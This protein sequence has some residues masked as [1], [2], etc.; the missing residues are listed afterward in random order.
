M[1]IPI[2]GISLITHLII[3]LVK[4]I[5]K[6][7]NSAFYRLK[8][9]FLR[10]GLKL[11]R[12]FCL[13]LFAKDTFLRQAFAFLIIIFFFSAILTTG[14]F[15]V[16]KLNFMQDSNFVLVSD[17][18]RARFVMAGNK[19]AGLE[20]APYQFNEVPFARENS[21]SDL[22]AKEIHEISQSIDLGQNTLP[23]SF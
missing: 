2:G 4:S 16:L 15:A 7:F 20:Q 19:N 23:N 11:S 18:V 17:L 9:N 13:V 21:Q 3:L 1:I 10:W 14:I 22:S 12:N 8:G 6:T 5:K